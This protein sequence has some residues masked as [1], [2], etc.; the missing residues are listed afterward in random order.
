AARRLDAD[1]VL[2]PGSHP[3]L[4]RRQGVGYATFRRLPPRALGARHLLSAVA[5]RGGVRVP[6]AHGRRHRADGASGP[7]GP[8]PMTDP[9]PLARIPRRSQLTRK[10]SFLGGC[11]ETAS[12]APT[13]AI[14][15]GGSGAAD[16][17][18]RPR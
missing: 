10:R 5:V 9:S 16:N 13:H 18:K 3:E 11:T 6:R 12:G 14:R 7:R 2:P 8:F 1:V 17:R 15:R 4:E